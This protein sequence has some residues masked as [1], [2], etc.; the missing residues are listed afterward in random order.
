MA[1]VEKLQIFGVG[2]K[3][4]KYYCCDCKMKLS[5]VRRLLGGEEFQRTRKDVGAVL[6]GIEACQNGISP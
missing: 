1:L 2:N 4:S 6:Q 5:A 3:L